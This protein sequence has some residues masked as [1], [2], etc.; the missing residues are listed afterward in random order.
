M[1]RKEVV[2][3][4]IMFVADLAGFVIERAKVQHVF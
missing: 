1:G 4:P 3:W 2:R